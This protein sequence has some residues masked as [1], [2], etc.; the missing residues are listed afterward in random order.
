VFRRACLSTDLVG[1]SIGRHLDR[2]RRDG[3]LGYLLPDGKTQ[4]AIEYHDRQPH[5]V[6]G[7]T[8]ITTTAEQGGRSVKALQDEVR[9]AVVEPAFADSDLKPDADT[10]VDINPDGALVGGPASHSGLT[11]RK[12]AVDTYGEYARQRRGVERQRSFTDRSSG[13]ICSPACRQKC[14]RR[15]A[16]ER[17]RDSAHLCHR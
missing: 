4:V 7:L 15:R 1:P 12:T 6:D 5:R 9:A 14:G 11:G 17:M 13:R 3:A 2:A 10:R 16:V 8:V